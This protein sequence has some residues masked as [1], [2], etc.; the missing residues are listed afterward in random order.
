VHKK[1]E[2]D[3]GEMQ[4]DEGG[5]QKPLPEALETMRTIVSCTEDHPLTHSSQ[6]TAA[7]LSPRTV[8]DTLQSR[9]LL[10]RS[11]CHH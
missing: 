8:Q 7:V 9:T 3:S 6:L 5:E 2:E 4:I 11:L 1:E 10:L